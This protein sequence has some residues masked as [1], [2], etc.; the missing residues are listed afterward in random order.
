MSHRRSTDNIYRVFK[1]C[2]FDH[3]IW[4]PNKGVQQGTRLIHSSIFYSW[5]VRAALVPFMFVPQGDRLLT[6]ELAW[7]IIE[8]FSKWQPLEHRVELCLLLP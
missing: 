3:I 8:A 1:V 2:K 5:N 6:L 7:V 4:F